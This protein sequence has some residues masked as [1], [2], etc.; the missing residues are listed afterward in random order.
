M[1]SDTP[2]REP[3]PGELGRPPVG[4]AA[5]RAAKRTPLLT[6]MALQV[7]ERRPPVGTAR[8]RRAESRIAKHRDGSR[9]GT[10][11]IPGGGVPVPGRA[12]AQSALRRSPASRGGADRRS[13]FPCP[14]A[15]LLD[16][17]C[18]A[19]PA[20]RGGA[21]RRSAQFS[22]WGL[23]CL[24]VAPSGGLGAMRHVQRPRGAFCDSASAPEYEKCGLPPRTPAPPDPS[25]QVQRE[26]LPNLLRERLLPGGAGLRCRKLR[27]SDG[28]F[29][30]T[31]RRVHR[32]Q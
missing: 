8:R 1:Q 11:P 2:A 7:R 20:S 22:R 32:R 9:L 18:A 29:E 14:A 12:P 31:V 15:L 19:R 5:R 6:R 30:I 24:R 3:P 16:R 23:P 25:L 4:T 17:H 27:R 21:D 10:V 13:A 28:Q 26:P